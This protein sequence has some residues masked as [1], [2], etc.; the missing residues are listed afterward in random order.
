VMFLADCCTTQGAFGLM[1]QWNE[2]LSTSVGHHIMLQELQHTNFVT[3]RINQEK[4]EFHVDRTGWRSDLIQ[5]VVLRVDIHGASSCFSLIMVPW[6]HFH[7]IVN[8]TVPKSTPA[9]KGLSKKG[10][11][12]ENGKRSQEK[13]KEVGAAIERTRMCKQ[14]TERV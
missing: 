8:E 4:R 5:K 11:V 13:N 12:N 3:T 6:S 9:R 1:P 14:G 2:I 10:G 7:G